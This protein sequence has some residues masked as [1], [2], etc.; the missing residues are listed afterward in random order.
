MTEIVNDVNHSANYVGVST[1]V[2]AVNADV[3]TFCDS[4]PNKDY[5]P[6]D[7]IRRDVESV[8]GG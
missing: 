3:N 5:T 1:I 6:A 2:D 4:S 8:Y 7:D